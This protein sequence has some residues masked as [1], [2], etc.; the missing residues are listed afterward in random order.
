MI[1]HA[2]VN[3]EEVMRNLNK[4]ASSTNETENLFETSMNY[5]TDFYN[6]DV[7]MIYLLDKDTGKAH[8]TGKKNVPPRYVESSSEMDE[9]SGKLWEVIKENKII[10]IKNVQEDE[11]FGFDLRSLNKKGALGIP[12]SL[13]YTGDAQGALWIF[14]DDEYNYDPQKDKTLLYLVN[15]IATS[16]AWAMKYEEKRGNWQERFK[17]S[18]NS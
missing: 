4:L 17:I 7:V 5:L 11:S 1:Q 10:N 2:E 18:L 13:S 3:Q 8:L 6:I 15:Q 14:S 12:I 16:I 9:S